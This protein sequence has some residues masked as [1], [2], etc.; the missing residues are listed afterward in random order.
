MHPRDF[1]KSKPNHPAY[2]MGNSG[3]TVTFKQLDQRSNQIAHLFRDHGVK[4][5]DTIAIF[6][7]NS[8][9]YFEIAW[10]AQRSGLYYVCIS[11]RLTPPEVQYILED[12]GSKIVIAS[13]GLKDVAEKTKAITSLEQYWS[14][15]GDIPGYQSL[16]TLRAQKPDTPV[17]DEMAGTDMLY[18]SGTTGRPKGIRPPL[19]PGTPID[20]DAAVRGW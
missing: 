10:A 2:I 9:R 3:E 12:S 4:P 19:E 16:E 6:A 1:A 17:A 5:G 20:E 13:A 14:I 8:A 18:S 7:E 11:S 15:D